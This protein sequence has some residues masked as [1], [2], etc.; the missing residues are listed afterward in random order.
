MVAA[1]IGSD[2]R[3]E[4]VDILLQNLQVSLSDIQGVPQV[5]GDDAHLDGASPRI[6]NADI[7]KCSERAG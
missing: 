6:P 4:L 1:A 5:V 7:A 2:E 3:E